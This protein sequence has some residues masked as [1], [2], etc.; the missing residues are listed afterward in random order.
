MNTPACDGLRPRLFL[1]MVHE[2]G[3]MAA[4]R[5][6]DAGAGK[7]LSTPASCAGSCRARVQVEAQYT[8]DAYE[9]HRAN[10]DAIVAL[11]PRTSRPA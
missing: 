1:K 7:T 5:P 6:A 4:W 9:E 10:V 11:L 2:T 3:L 8:V